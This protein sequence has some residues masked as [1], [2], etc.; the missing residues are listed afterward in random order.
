V[1]E[2]DATLL[3]VDAEND[4]ALLRAPFHGREIARLRDKPSV[5]AGE[6]IVVVGFPLLGI[7]ATQANV[8]TGVVSSLAGIRNDAR[9]LQISAPVQPGNSG[10]P[11]LDMGGNVIGLVSAKLDAAKVADV[12]GDLPENVNF[13][14]NAS[15]IRSLLD[16]QSIPY[17]TGTFAAQQSAADVGDIGKSISDLVACWK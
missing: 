11:L 3:A 8:T 9:Y 4:L 10:G 13:A 12:T 7:L 17:R 5:R 6:E 2:G 14:I 16:S 15:V 1:P